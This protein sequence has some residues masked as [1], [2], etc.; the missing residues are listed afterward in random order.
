LVAGSSTGTVVGC[1]VMLAD[2]GKHE[3]FLVGAG[4]SP[5]E[6]AGFRESR[7]RPDGND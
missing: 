5:A 7:R 3:A 2:P 4:V 6:S 1:S